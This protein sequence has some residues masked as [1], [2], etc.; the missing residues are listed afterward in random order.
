MRVLPTIF[1][2]LV[3]LGAS[4]FMRLQNPVVPDE[5]TNPEYLNGNGDWADSVLASLSD[6]EKI[7]QLFMV[8][9]YSNK[10]EEHVQ[11]IET[12]IKEQKIGGLIFFQGGPYREA[13]LT[14]HYQQISKVPLMVSIDGEW[15]LA[16]RLDS[17]VKYPWQMTLGA[18]QDNELIYKMGMDIGEQC[19]RLGIHVNLAPV[20]DINVN[21]ANP[22][23]NARSFGEDRENVAQKGIAYMKGMQDVGV[24]ANAKH[25]P[26]HGDT[27]KDSHKTLPVITHTRKRLDSIELYPF[28][29]LIEKGLGSVMVAH[30]NIPAYVK[31]ANTATTLSKEVVTDLL[32]DSLQ[33]KG[34]AFTD[35]LNMKG[36]SDYYKPGEADLK[37]LLA[38]N[39][40]LLF[41]KDVPLAI[42]MIEQALDSGWIAQREIDERCLKILRAKQWCGLDKN[43]HVDTHHLYEDLNKPAYEHLNRVLFESALTMLENKKNLLPLKDIGNLKMLSISF[44]ADT[45]TPFQE[46]IDLYKEVTHLYYPRLTPEAQKEI[47][48]TIK[49]YD[50]AIV[51]IHKSDKSPWSSYEIKPSL[52]TFINLLRIKIPIALTVFANPYSLR[53]FEGV[54]YCTSV[55]MAYQNNVYAQQAA[56]QAI[57]GGIPMNGR[58]PVSISNKYKAGHGMDQKEVIRFKY[59]DPEDVGLDSRIFMRIDSLALNGIDEGA[60]PGCQVLIAKD[61]KVIYQKA[62]GYH[63]YDTLHPVKITDVY[64]LASVT[65]IG[66]SAASLMKLQSDGKLSLDYNLC[67]YLGEMVDTTHYMNLNL[68]EILSHQ[69]GLVAWIPFYIKTLSNGNPSNRYYSKDSSATF[70]VK[71]ADGLYIHKDYPEVIMKRILGTRL[72]EKEYRYSDLGYYFVKEIVKDL[73]GMPINEF[74]DSVFYKPMGM[75]TTMYLPLQ[76]L[77]LDRIVPTEDDKIFRKQVVHGYVHDPGA[78]MLGGVGGHAGLF[79]SANDF[80]K[81]MQM[82]LNWGE[83]GGKRYLDSA[84]IKEFTSCQFCE[85]NRRAAAFDKPVAEGGGPTCENISLNSYGH[86]GFTGTIA[87]NDP[88]EKVVYIFLSNRVYPSADNKKLVTMNIRTN[89]QQVIYDAIDKTQGSSRQ[90]E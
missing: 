60:Y 70:S 55:I 30:L 18:I 24:M 68:R 89:I 75:S 61:G 80:A 19:K 85:T 59:T 87:W 43:K 10:G 72:L 4:A 86:S 82:Y 21:P 88:D 46:Q 34:L 12:L 14:N 54:E 78:A 16:M 56:A 62:F 57:F 71:V 13:R 38:G 44:G 42:Q 67:D 5:P 52:K 83:Y 84:V 81:L 2:I 17:T 26:G 6:R 47:L 32:K 7:A 69:S 40:V 27:D 58:L 37:A 63:T 53:E 76:R 1:M 33:F 74:A 50:L 22:V 9:A 20:V 66:A 8:A 28:K 3:F 39:D 11:E 90:I 31:E 51:G 35:A 65:K 45:I 64:D 73:T 15:G 77:P 48:D 41:P 23:I 79:S 25:F 29:K 36:V 49:N